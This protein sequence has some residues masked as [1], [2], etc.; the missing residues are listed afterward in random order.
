MTIQ[1]SLIN[2]RFILVIAIMCIDELDHKYYDKQTFDVLQY[3]V[4]S[5]S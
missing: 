1:I 4:H 3:L 5:K 2:I